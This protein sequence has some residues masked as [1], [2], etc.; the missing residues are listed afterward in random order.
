MD[1]LWKVVDRIDELIVAVVA[2][3]TGGFIGG[4]MALRAANDSIKR[5]AAMSRQ[6]RQEAEAAARW[7]ALASL[8]AELHLNAALIQSDETEHTAIDPAW[9]IPFRDAYVNALPY[10]ASLPPDVQQALQD[11]A[12][13][14]SHYTAAVD[15]Y[16]AQATQ[17]KHPAAPSQAQANHDRLT[18]LAPT[19]SD[20][21]ENAAHGLAA[22]LAAAA[23]PGMTGSAGTAPAPG[24]DASA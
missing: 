7:Q 16:N 21:F 10:L 20:R 13:I 24:P 9:R 15:R 1:V 3:S 8:E 2:A 18:Q 12:V 6:E 23:P 19:V 5:S 17:G 22:Y 11:A 4:W 14:S